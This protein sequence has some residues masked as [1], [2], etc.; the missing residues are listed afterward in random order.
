MEFEPGDLVR[1]RSGGP[2][3][4][5]ESVG[6]RSYGL[7]LAVWCVWFEATGNKQV[8]KR[9]TFPPIVLEKSHKP[10]MGSMRISRA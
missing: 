6:E 9:E 2:L 4:T 8:A 3:M 5:V 10:T 7:G 1:L